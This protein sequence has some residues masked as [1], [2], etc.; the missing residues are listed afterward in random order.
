MDSVVDELVIMWKQLGVSI[1]GARPWGEFFEVFKPPVKTDLERRMS[2]NLVYYKANYCQLV[3][4]IMTI[5]VLVSPRT[6]L[7]TLV[8]VAVTAGV[9]LIKLNSIPVGDVRVPLT[10]RNRGLAA[11]V[12]AL[13]TFSVTGA[14][15]WVVFTL[16]IALTLALGHMAF[17]PRTLAAKYN[18][19]ADDVK[20][21][22]FGGPPE[23]SVEDGL[24]VNDNGGLHSRKARTYRQ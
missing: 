11:G 14:L 21:L 3:G 9:F 15:L 8:S 1:Q 4:S 12:V 19:A 13:I 10:K 6:I 5:A 23:D 20:T 2:T 18:A 17:R 16:S 22:F 7:A 24:R